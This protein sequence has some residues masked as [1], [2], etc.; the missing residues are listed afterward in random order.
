MDR[1]QVVMMDLYFNSHP[2]EEDDNTLSLSIC[3][4]HISTHILAKRMTITEEW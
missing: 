3:L 4:L 2:R 1:C